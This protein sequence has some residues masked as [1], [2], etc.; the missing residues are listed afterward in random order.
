[1]RYSPSTL[2]ALTKGGL[3]MSGNHSVVDFRG[4]S[5]DI[6]DV[7]CRESDFDQLPPEASVFPKTGWL[8]RHDSRQVLDS[9][10]IIEALGG[11]DSN[12][13]ILKNIT[14]STKFR[15]FCLNI[16]GDE[17]Y[18]AVYEFLHFMPGWSMYV[19][20]YTANEFHLVKP[21]GLILFAIKLA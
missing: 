16:Q 7:Q 13:S 5:H 17:F 12:F 19:N 21:Y 11:P 3:L 9:Q 1:M 6:R 15:I 18:T 4:E 20:I 2:E 10:S 8:S 14:S